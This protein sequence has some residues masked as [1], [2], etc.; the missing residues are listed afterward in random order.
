MKIGKLPGINDVPPPPGLSLGTAWQVRFI[1]LNF[2]P[3][4]LIRCGVVYRNGGIGVLTPI[5]IYEEQDLI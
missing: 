2:F 5:T 4:V 1:M 3:T